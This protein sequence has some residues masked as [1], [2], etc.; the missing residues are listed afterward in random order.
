MQPFEVRWNSLIMRLLKRGYY[1]EVNQV[2]ND[3]FSLGGLF[4]AALADMYYTGVGALGYVTLSEK[5]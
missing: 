5:K 4:C 2:R 1:D 3:F